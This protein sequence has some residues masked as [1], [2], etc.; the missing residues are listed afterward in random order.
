MPTMTVP[1][2]IVRFAVY[3]RDKTTSAERWVHLLTWNDERAA[4]VYRNTFLHVNS[5]YKA[6]DV[7]IFKAVTTFEE[8]DVK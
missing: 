8:I 5:N 1:K 3:R 4:K 7:R 6:E 2:A